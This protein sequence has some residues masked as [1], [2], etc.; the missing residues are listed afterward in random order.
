MKEACRRFTGGSLPHV[1]SQRL[2]D[3][4]VVPP[5]LREVAQ[6]FVDLQ[7]QRHSADYDLTQTFTKEEVLS[8]IGQAEY[9]LTQFGRVDNPMSKKF[10]LSCLWA[11]KGI[12]E[13]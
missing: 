1:I 10:F 8:L 4:F 11:W 6:A 12:K 9:A 3:D 5:A 7:E 13:R 2:P